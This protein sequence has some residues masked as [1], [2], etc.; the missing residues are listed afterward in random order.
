VLVHPGRINL[1]SAVTGLGALLILVLAARTRFAAFGTLLTV[2]LP[3]V[4]VALAGADSVARVKDSGP[5]QPGIP[6]PALPDIHLL[7]YGIITGALAVAVIIMVQGAGVA[8]A[9]RP[10]GPGRHRSTATSLPRAS[11]TPPPRPRCSASQPT[12]PIWRGRRGSPA[13][14]TQRQRM[15]I[16]LIGEP[17]PAASRRGAMTQRND[18]RPADSQIA[19]RSSNRR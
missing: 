6:A 9:A 1:A 7:T 14:P 11:A 2:V 3:T 13:V 8:E 16:G 19:I 4:V 12:A 17:V 10:A 18:Q 15:A 5:I